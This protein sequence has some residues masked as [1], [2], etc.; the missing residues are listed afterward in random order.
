MSTISQ[1][2]SIDGFFGKTRIR[3]S[4]LTLSEDTDE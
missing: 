4:R 2:I 1:M 3:L